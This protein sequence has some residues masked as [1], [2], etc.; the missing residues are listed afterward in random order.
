MVPP[1]CVRE[2]LGRHGGPLAHHQGGEHDAVARRQRRVLSRRER[3]QHA[4]VHGSNVKVRPTVVNGT[5]NGLIT[6]RRPG[7]NAPRCSCRHQLRLS[8]GEKHMKLIHRHLAGVTAAAVA[9]GLAAVAVPITPGA[10]AGQPEPAEIA[11]AWQGT[12]LAT[13]PFTPAQALYLS[14]TS[15]A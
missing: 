11:L 5:D 1:E 2:L 8:P 14:Y 9:A 7:D 3:P 15:T 4:D 10:A 6:R 13:V 12:A